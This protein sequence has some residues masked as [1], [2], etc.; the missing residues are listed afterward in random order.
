MHCEAIT[1]IIEEMVNEFDHSMLEY[2]KKRDRKAPD[3]QISVL[4]HR[5]G[6]TDR[7]SI[8]AL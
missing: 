3:A 8:D 4:Y 6:T 5:L 7:K 2:A 1:V